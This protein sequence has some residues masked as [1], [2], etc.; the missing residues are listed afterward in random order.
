M[1]VGYVFLIFAPWME[2]P[3]RTPA[4]A[5]FQPFSSVRP[6]PGTRLTRHKTP[7]SDGYRKIQF[8]SCVSE[9]G[10]ASEG[11]KNWF[12]RGAPANRATRQPN[13]QCTQCQ[14]AVHSFSVDGE[15]YSLGKSN[16]WSLRGGRREIWIDF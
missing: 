6:V 16:T 1:Y 10:G 5:L 7:P 8:L 9:G 11:F 13:K 12:E 4:L 15:A 3:L 14:T 2:V